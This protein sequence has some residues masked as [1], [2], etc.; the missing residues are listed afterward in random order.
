METNDSN[1]F[2][3]LVDSNIHLK[4]FGW[5]LSCT[6]YCNLKIGK[7]SLSALLTPEY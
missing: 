6:F 3:M 2:T 4:R 5:S 7:N 1:K